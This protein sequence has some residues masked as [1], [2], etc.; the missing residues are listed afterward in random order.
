MI[1]F[2]L[3]VFSEGLK[4]V[5]KSISNATAGPRNAVNDAL[6]K[7]NNASRPVINKANSAVDATGNWLDNAKSRQGIDNSSII[8][9]ARNSVLEFPVY[10]SQS[11]RVNEAQILAGLF[12][13]EYTTLVQS[14]LSA[15]VIISEEEANNFM[16]L[17]G[18]HTNIKEAVDFM[19]S[20]YNEFYEPI[21]DFDQRLQDSIYLHQQLT[22]NV[23]VTFK[24]VPTLDQR[25]IKECSRMTTD[26]LEG[27]T[28]LVEGSS[29]VVPDSPYDPTKRKLS[30]KEVQKLADDRNESVLELRNTL[31]NSDYNG[32]KNCMKHKN[33]IYILDGPNVYEVS[34]HTGNKDSST[35]TTI[36]YET[37]TDKKAEEI[38]NTKNIDK[39]KKEIKDGNSKYKNYRIGSDGNIQVKSK[40]TKDISI[41]KHYTPGENIVDKAVKAPSLLRENDIKKL[42]SLQPYSMQVNFRVR[43]SNG[44]YYDVSYIIGIKTVMHLIRTSDM[45]DDLQELVTGN[46]RSLQKVKYKTGEINFLNYMF[47]IKGLKAD[48]VKKINPNKRWLNTL[49]RLGEFNKLNG[50]ILKTPADIVNFLG[51]ESDIAIPNG[52]MILTQTDISML[53]SSTGIDLSVVSNARKLCDSL[54]LIAIAIVDSSAGTMRILHYDPKRT[55]DWE[56]H[57]LAAVDAEVSKTDNSQLMKELN[58]LVNK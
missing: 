47:N 26:C 14:V 50:T 37:I 56:A 55:T 58:H 4:G 21:D 17:K 6:T 36:K 32:R 16:F 31:R 49:K 3:D 38:F 19:C 30:V 27:F 35:E 11:I 2:G 25:I 48:A 10:V 44:N 42:N 33:T 12:E 45:V 24:V 20:A 46:V 28:Y 7:A 9:R 22:E 39:I 18:Y 29:R 23:E 40:S 52:T 34:T 57:S 53:A 41:N 43:S 1:D 5:K 15:N 54:F 13:R 8:T 51:G